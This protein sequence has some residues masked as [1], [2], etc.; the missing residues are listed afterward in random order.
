LP[1]RAVFFDLYGTLAAF[2]P[3][4]EVIQMRA[5][6]GWGMTLSKKGIDA[7]YVL[8]EGLMASQ[9]A[10][11]P[12]HLLAAAEREEFFARYEQLVL[13]GAGHEVGIDVAA[14]IWKEVRKQKYQLALYPD[15]IPGVKAVRDTLAAHGRQGPPVLGVISNISYRGQ[16]LCDMLGLTGHVDF[17]VTSTEVGSAKPNP[18]IFLAALAKAGVSAAE[19]A[20]V[21]DQLDSDIE[22]A[23]GAGIRP[24][25][26]D[27]DGAHRGYTQ[28][29]RVEGMEELPEV[30]QLLSS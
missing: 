7:G 24:V 2:D 14:R 16:E 3:P 9:N 30:L 18:P 11:H 27:R 20:H 19:A 10:R 28:H 6:A 26:M 12:V 13:R 22:G 5:T 1:I 29:P 4:R 21:G 25:L 17:A 8:A 15:V 23:L